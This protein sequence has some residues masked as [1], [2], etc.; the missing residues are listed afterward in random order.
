MVDASCRFRCSI[1]LLWL[2]PAAYVCWLQHYLNLKYTSILLLANIHC[3]YILQLSMSLCK[4]WSLHQHLDIHF[5]L[6]CWLCDATV[7]LSANVVTTTEDSH[8][9]ICIYIYLLYKDIYIYIY[10]VDIYIYTYCVYIYIFIYCVCIY[11][12][13][14]YYIYICLLY[15][16]RD[17]YPCIDDVH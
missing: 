2:Q 6:S 11:I 16:H 3:R 15:I 17:G 7:T 5:H 4:V 8:M 9:Q 14:V 13:I 12:Y 10:C 1:P